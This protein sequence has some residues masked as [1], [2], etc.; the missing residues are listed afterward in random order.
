M[1][2][3]NDTQLR[4][5]LA[6]LSRVEPVALPQEKRRRR[7]ALVGGL[8]ALVVLASGVAIADGINPF[9]GIGAANHAQRSQDVLPAAVVA[10][11]KQSNARGA[12]IVGYRMHMLPNTAR[13]LDTLSSCTRIYVISTTTDD[14]CVLIYADRGDFGD[15]CGAPLTQTEPTTIGQIDKVK[16]GPHATPPLT[17]GVARNGITAV[18]FRAHGHQTTVAVKN[19][20]WAY[21]GQNGAL[22]S[23][24]IHYTNGTTRTLVH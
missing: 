8:V 12:T 13:L 1:T 22:R 24:T 11:I 19:N 5:L 9:A 2:S 7:P 15:G 3:F 14:L 23:L 17:F 4:A 10:E 18:S 6:P 20:V 21:E 16:N